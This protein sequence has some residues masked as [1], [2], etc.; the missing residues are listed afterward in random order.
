MPN[1]TSAVT[2]ADIDRLIA[3]HRAI[4][5]DTL[6]NVERVIN[7][8]MAAGHK[9]PKRTLANMRKLGLRVPNES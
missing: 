6:P 3:E 7:E 2:A 5:K 9:V 1:E 4:V 8:A